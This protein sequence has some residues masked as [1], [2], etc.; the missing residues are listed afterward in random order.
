MPSVIPCKVSY[1]KYRTPTEISTAPI[2]NLEIGEEGR[3]KGEVKRQV[4]SSSL[5]KGCP[6][7]SLAG[8]Y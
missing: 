6:W 1:A 3:E 8:P 5:R 4:G 7:L 2:G